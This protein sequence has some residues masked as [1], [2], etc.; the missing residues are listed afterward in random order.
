MLKHSRPIAQR[1]ADIVLK[2]SNSEKEF[3]DKIQSI[4]GLRD[5]NKI[6]TL[7]WLDLMFNHLAIDPEIL[8][9]LFIKENEL[10]LLED[11]LFF[12]SSQRNIAY[13]ISKYVYRIS[14]LDN[15]F[16]RKLAK[17]V[18]CFNSD[19][20][21][22]YDLLSGLWDYD[23]SDNFADIIFNEFIKTDVPLLN[24]FTLEHVFISTRSDS[25]FISWAEKKIK[26]I[27]TE[28]EYTV[29]M[30]LVSRLPIER[31]IGIY[32]ECIKKKVTIGLFKEILRLP[33]FS[34][35]SGSEVN[36][37]NPKI[38]K[39]AK[40]IE[41]VPAGVDYLEYKKCLEDYRDSL[42]RYCKQAKIREKVEYGDSF[43]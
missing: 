39:I 30:D 33:S 34:S 1:R 3:I 12:V 40:L 35:W 2:F 38:G 28:E 37:I 32:I 29:L 36:A 9:N 18:F 17:R 24:T 43:L 7:C 15:D 10:K 23:N 21:S 13:E 20:H 6:K 5:V 11:I 14:F 26:T 27:A 41:S 25:Q 4:Y 31:T 22:N 16:L 8:F 42:V 19:I